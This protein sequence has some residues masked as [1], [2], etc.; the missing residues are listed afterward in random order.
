MKLG[1][2][3]NFTREDN[4]SPKPNGFEDVNNMAFIESKRNGRPAT[5]HNGFW[6]VQDEAPN[7]ESWAKRMNREKKT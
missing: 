3:G 4:P 7:S 1:H 2:R 5:W 6:Y